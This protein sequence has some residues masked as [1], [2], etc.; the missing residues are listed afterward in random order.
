VFQR[1]FHNFG[2]WFR[3]KKRAALVEIG[4]KGCAAYPF[5]WDDRSHKIMVG[6]RVEAAKGLSR[7]PNGKIF[8]RL[9]P[10][11]GLGKHETFVF[12]RPNS[13]LHQSDLEHLVSRA[14]LRFY[15]TGRAAASERL[16]A[17]PAEIIFLNVAVWKTL[18]DGRELLDPIGSNGTQF[19]IEIGGT[20]TRKNILSSFPQFDSDWH[21]ATASH[22]PLAYLFSKFNKIIQPALFVA[23]GPRETIVF[24][25]GPGRAFP[26][27]SFAW[28][29]ECLEKS[30]ARVLSVNN[31]IAREIRATYNNNQQHV[32]P[33]TWRS[34]GGLINAEYQL[35]LNGVR[36]AAAHLPEVSAHIYARQSIPDFVWSGDV[37]N[38]NGREVRLCPVAIANWSDECG[39]ALR[40]ADKNAL[41]HAP[42]IAAEFIY[43]QLRPRN[44]LVNVIAERKRRWL[45]ANFNKNG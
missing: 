33:I 3:G 26:Y 10:D 8:L 2:S 4:A 37:K 22:V 44:N 32:S 30:V 19:E 24:G 12:E 31:E 17:N 11:A 35:L 23:V 39:Y 36:V 40:A 27:D 29:E 21:D 45:S 15:E 5:S 14:V 38:I 13:P 7:F 43:E 18:I 25:V 41:P 34:I 28:G 1:L 6:K 16:A 9:A 42:E 20:F